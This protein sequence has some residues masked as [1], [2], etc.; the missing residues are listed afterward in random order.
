MRV[1]VYLGQHIINELEAYGPLDVVVDQVL[2]L[3][4]QG[5]ID[6]VGH[7]RCRPRT[8]DRRVEVEVVNEYYIALTH[9]YPSR[10]TMTSLRRLLYWF[11][12]NDLT[13]MLTP[14]TEYTLPDRESDLIVARYKELVRT[15]ARLLHDVKAAPAA[16]IAIAER[17]EAAHNILEVP[18][19]A[20]S[21]TATTSTSLPDTD[22]S[23]SK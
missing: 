17:L 8:L 9:D 23:S 15:T 22:T 21:S 12:E 4:E 10:S 1:S 19:C 3:G 14:A 16:N 5:L 7:P 6:L 2:R 11:V 20:T 18:L 13:V